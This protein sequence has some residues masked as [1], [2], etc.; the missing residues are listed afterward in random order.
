MSLTTEQRDNLIYGL[1]DCVLILYTCDACEYFPGI[2]QGLID[3]DEIKI[4][5]S[6]EGLSLYWNYRKQAFRSFNEFSDS[7]L[8]GL[9]DRV[10]N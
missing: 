7:E 3:D 9:F 2:D 4:M 1:N 5:G 8:E 6:E 10:E